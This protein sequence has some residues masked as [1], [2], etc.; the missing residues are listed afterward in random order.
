VIDSAETTEGVR[1]RVAVKTTMGG[2]IALAAIV[3]SGCAVASTTPPTTTPE[4]TQ[5]QAF[6][7]SA[8]P[9]SGT[10]PTEPHPGAE[11][12]IPD[13][14]RSVTID[15]A[16]E[17][18]SPYTVEVGD[19]M[20]MNQAVLDGTCDGTTSMAWPLSED[21]RP[22]LSIWL[23]DGVAWTATP[24]FSADAFV[25]DETIAAECAAFG[26]VY[27]ALMN[28]DQGAVNYKAFGTDEWTARVDAAAADLEE[29]VDSSRTAMAPGFAR[30]L[31]IAQSPDRAP[32]SVTAGL[33]IADLIG[34]DCG[35]NH[36]P[37]V[38][39]AEF[40]G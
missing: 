6:D 28:A 14:A 5:E 31:A 21:T 8:E 15:V 23:P 4:P 39:N 38:L 35:L 26:E 12:P 13:G 34:P 10:G 33:N 16:C 36:T 37:L 40:G 1:V 30:L 2:V 27:S 22:T 9:L 3:L 29:L 25:T 19:A 11:F 17:G 32:G 7:L 24:H 20:A 18:G